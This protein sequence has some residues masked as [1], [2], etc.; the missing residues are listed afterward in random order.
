MPVN[1][2]TGGWDQLYTRTSL[3]GR[4]QP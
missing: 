3:N 4:G 2:P 1:P